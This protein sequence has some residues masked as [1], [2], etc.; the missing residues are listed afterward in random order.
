MRD[1]IH[2]ATVEQ[3][4]HRLVE[5]RIHRHAVA[6]VG[7]LVQRA[8]AVLL[9]TVAVDQRHRHLDAIAGRHP[10]TLGGVLRRVIADHRLL[11][12]LATLTGDGVE[13]VGGG[14]G[15][16]RGVGVPQPRRIV[17]AV[18]GQPHRIGRLVGLDVVLAA[19]REQ[20][21]H[22]LQAIGALGDRGEAI[23]QLEAFDQH[24]IIVRDPV[25]PLAARGG[26]A[27]R[28]DDLEVLRISIV[29][30]D[31]P[32]AVEV[33]GVVFHVACTRCQHLERLR[34]GGRGVARFRADRA[35]QFDGQETIIA[36]AAD[37]HVEAV[38]LLFVDQHVTAGR[39]AQNVLF[40]AHGEQRFRIVLDVEQ[41]AVVIGPD[42]VGRDVLDT[43]RQHF[44][45]AQVL[46]TDHVL[47]SAHIIFGPGQQM[48]VL[49]DI[50]IAH[51]EVALALGHRVDVEQDFF[52]RLHA[53]LAACLDRVVLAGFKAGVIPVAAVTR[54]HA[55]IILLDAGDDLLVERVFQR[56]ER[57]HDLVGI[58]I[59]RVQV[60]QHFLVFALVVA[61]PVVIIAAGRA[62]GSLHRVRVLL[63]VGRGQRGGGVHVGG[64]EA[65]NQ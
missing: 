5:A 59:L 41:G 11:L 27:G 51:V 36:G 60:R 52:R 16:Q 30:A 64:H 4:D 31:H 25:F 40:H 9:E 15:G 20:Q 22:A 55:G 37:A 23:E 18:G 46:E 13:L 65:G 21:A 53:A 14:R 35:V 28:G 24:R 38:V 44:T 12:E 39:G 42:H 26:I 58:G 32:A 3:A 1:G 33:V 49:A 29:G 2:H 50:G 61:Q 56:L 63:G 43:V 19:I 7:V 45:G 17:F 47:A 10:H 6:A 34:I 8:G 54:G 48:V 62:K 57:R